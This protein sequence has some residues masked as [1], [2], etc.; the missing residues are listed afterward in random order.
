MRTVAQSTY[1]KEDVFEQDESF[2]LPLY[3]YEDCGNP[4][5]QSGFLIRGKA[6]IISGQ[7]P[8]KSIVTD[9]SEVVYRFENINP[10]LKYEVKATYSAPLGPVK[11]VLSANDMALHTPM[12]IGQTT[13]RTAWLSV[14]NEA[15]QGDM[16]ELRI[17]KT[18]GDGPAS[19]AEI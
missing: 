11:Q 19:V 5:F 6:E 8:E 15:L 2:Y 3:Y 18:G 16:L 12:L 1:G 14:P 10:V 4:G 9:E 13:P 17:Q 7:A